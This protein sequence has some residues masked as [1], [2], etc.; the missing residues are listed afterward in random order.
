M[1]CTSRPRLRLRECTT[2]VPRVTHPLPGVPRPTRGHRSTM[3]RNPAMPPARRETGPHRGTYDQSMS[4]SSA[5][6]RMVS[7]SI[8]AACTSRSTSRSGHLYHERCQRAFR[9]GDVHSRCTI[10]ESGQRR[11]LPRR[12]R[13]QGL[14]H[15]RFHHAG[16][17]CMHRPLMRRVLCHSLSPTPLSAALIR[18]F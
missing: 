7:D 2:Y 8:V 10:V 11:T 13:T 6:E 16:S 17:T 15:H 9:C 4:A 1:R 14:Q 3:M 12:A 18:C 5:L